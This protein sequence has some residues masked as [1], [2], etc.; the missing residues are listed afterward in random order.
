MVNISS[1]GIMGS[2]SLLRIISFASVRVLPTLKPAAC[3]ASSYLCKNAAKIS[4][5]ATDA[6][7]ITS[8][9]LIMLVMNGAEA[10]ADA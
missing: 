6:R 1:A 7:G 9:L 8:V 2:A 5:L 3:S 10:R 4:T